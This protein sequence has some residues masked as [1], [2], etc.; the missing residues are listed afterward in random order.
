MGKQ[1]AGKDTFA[2]FLQRYGFRAYALA[3]PLKAIVNGQFDVCDKLGVDQK[4]VKKMCEKEDNSPKKRQTLIAL[5]KYVRNINPYAFVQYILEYTDI[6]FQPRAV[7]TDVRFKNE[8]EEF[9]N[10]GF[11]PVR[12]EASLESRARRPEF[13][14][15]AEGTQ[16]ET[17]LDDFPFA[18]VI[19]NDGTVDEFRARSEM[20]MK[21]LL[22]RC[23]LENIYF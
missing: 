20:F 14:L 6:M 11:L 18:F 19:R 23:D 12:I 3:D 8:Y 10:L 2:G 16:S 15:D 5:G 7:V 17:D 4:V 22:R 21:Y 13:D 1:R 9:I